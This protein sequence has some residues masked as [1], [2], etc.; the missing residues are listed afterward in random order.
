MRPALRPAQNIVEATASMDNELAILKEN[1]TQLL[2]WK[3]QHFENLSRIMSFPLSPL[4]EPF[5]LTA[6]KD[7]K[8]PA[9]SATLVTDSG[10]TQFDDDD[11]RMDVESEEDFFC[12]FDLEGEE[13]TEEGT[14]EVRGTAF[15]F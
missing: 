13:G 14:E 10:G 11:G 1:F 7:S 4:E 8:F 3:I 12:P 5:F 15:W 6:M 2:S 9:K